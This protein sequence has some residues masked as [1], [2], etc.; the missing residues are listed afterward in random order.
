MTMLLA[1]VIVAVM[2]WALIKKY[3]TRMVLIAGGLALACLAADPLEPLKA[4]SAS[5][6]QSKIFEVIISCMGFA[7]VIKLTGCHTHLIAIFVKLLKKAG[8]FVIIGAALATMVVNSAI[9]SAAGTSAAVGT[10]LIPLLIA[11]RVPAPIAAATIIAGL[12]GG[13]LNPGHVHPTIVAELA[14][15]TGVDFVSLVYFPLI[16]SVVVASCVLIVLSYYMKKKG[17]YQETALEEGAGELPKDFKPNLF[18]AVIPLLPLI[19]L[20]LGNFGYVKFLKMPVSHAMI[21]GAVIAMIATRTGPGSITKTFFKGMGDAF[22]SIFGIIIAANIFVAGL[23]SCG[24]IKALIDYMSGSPMIAKA[25]SVVGPFFVAVLSGSGE[26]ASI[27]FNNAVSAHATQFGL[28]IMNM[29]AMTVLSGG[30]GRSLSPVA[31]AMIICAGIA[32]VSPMT[33]SRWISIPM[34]CALATATF[35]L[36]VL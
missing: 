3:E 15:K 32:K 10:I 28:E 19:I 23:K 14:G 1:A 30:I 13:N 7:A 12:Y 11:A 21:I 26:A 27:A 36:Y 16:S 6:K 35:I 9:P 4:F 8:P 18:L 31:G 22:G 34:L 2:V 5:M 33:V 20:L 17:L 29:G 24:I 25:A